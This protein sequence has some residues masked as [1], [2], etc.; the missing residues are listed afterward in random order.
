MVCGAVRNGNLEL[1]DLQMLLFLLS[2]PRCMPA[3]L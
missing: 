1:N 3:P 2:S